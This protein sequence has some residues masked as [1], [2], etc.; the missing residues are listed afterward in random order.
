MFSSI[1]DGLHSA[2]V[3]AKTLGIDDMLVDLHD[4]YFL[5]TNVLLIN[6]TLPNLWPNYIIFWTNNTELNM[7]LNQM[8]C[9][10]FIYLTDVI[11]LFKLK[12]TNES[13]IKRV[14]TVIDVCMYNL[15][16]ILNEKF[17]YISNMSKDN[18]DFPDY[19]Y[20]QLI[21]SMM[22]FLLKFLTKEPIIKFFSVYAKKQIYNIN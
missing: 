7:K 18:L 13:I 11:R 22:N 5:S 12:I 3:R 4:K 20:Q 19:N 15:E 2:C 9:N 17:D 21:Y 1:Y 14:S 10:C 6:F 8:K 16:F